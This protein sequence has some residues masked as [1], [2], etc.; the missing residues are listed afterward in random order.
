MTA[1]TAAVTG[2]GHTPDV[3]RDR[4]ASTERV[5]L[6]ALRALASGRDRLLVFSAHPDD[7]SIGAGRLLSAWRRTGTAARAD[8]AT[9]G[10]A[11]F[12][13]VGECPTGLAE[14][15]LVEWR[16]AL[17][18][19]DV[20]AGASYGLPDGGLDEAAEALAAAVGRTV[21]GAGHA[22]GLVLLAPHPSDPHPDHR[23]VGRAAARV[24]AGLGIPV[25]HFGIWMTYW[26]DP[27]V[28]LGGRLV[29]VG[30]DDVDDAA[31]DVAVRC[32]HSQL[33]PWQPGWGA[34]VPPE[35]LAHHDRQLLVLPRQDP[36]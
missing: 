22:D 26:S 12:D 21:A 18:A 32:F 34:V 30:V 36:A 6:S 29:T 23:A 7:E 11:C 20:E 27:E 28:D 35:M 2:P 19:L 4:I 5:S 9:A 3:W 15:R 31:W 33:E 24:G 1:S 17:A 25:W 14:Q 16:R 8:L 10:E 13:H